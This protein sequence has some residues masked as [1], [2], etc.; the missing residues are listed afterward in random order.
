MKT[1]VEKCNQILFVCIV[2]VDEFVTNMLNYLVVVFD[3]GH[4]VI[5]VPQETPCHAVVCISGGSDPHNANLHTTW[6]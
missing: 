4:E 5:A 2:L 1:N 3:C 6:R